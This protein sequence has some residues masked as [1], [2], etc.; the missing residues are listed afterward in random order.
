V[1]NDLAGLEPSPAQAQVS[2]LSPHLRGHVFFFDRKPTACDAATAIRLVFVFVLLE[3]LLGPRL[4]ILG[5]FHL[6]VPAASIRVPG[7][8]AVALLLVRVVGRTTFSTVGFRRWRDW[9]KTERSYFVQA[10]V[11]AHIVFFFIAARRLQVVAGAPELWGTVAIMVFTQLAWGIYQ[12]LAYRGILQTALVARWP[13][14]VGIL[15]ANTA[16]TF[17]PL[18]IYHVADAAPWPMFAGIFA[19]GLFFS[20]LFHR[21]KNLW[22]VG[23]LHGLGNVYMDGLSQI[24]P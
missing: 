9:G 6:S 18:H 1:L 16:F 11:I 8:L 14:V 4:S 10:V 13:P 17:G 15:I 12:E 5:R 7:L 24:I 20:L 3:G 21:S 19:I 23:V 2:R 22:M